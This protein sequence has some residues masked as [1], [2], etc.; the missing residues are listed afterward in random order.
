MHY[1]FVVLLIENK[2]V[3]PGIEEFNDWPHGLLA[4]GTFGIN[5]VKGD[6]QRSNFRG[7]TES[8][9]EE[10]LEGLTSEEVLGEL[11]ELNSLILLH[12][13]INEQAA[14]APEL[15]QKDTK[16]NL[17]PLEE[18]ANI[19]SSLEAHEATTNNDNSDKST[20]R[21]GG[22]KHSNIVVPSKGKN[23][24]LDNTKNSIGKKSLSFLLKKMFVCGSGFPPASSLR[25]PIPESRMEKVISKS[26]HIHENA[27]KP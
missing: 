12:E 6:L 22:H 10:H 21:N 5:N 8:S 27:N 14:S 25:D 23:I 13:Q 3:G 9:S 4:I 7:K 15:E 16:N 2:V 24:C 11:Q 1:F 18:F 26:I 20:G 19:Q 17:V